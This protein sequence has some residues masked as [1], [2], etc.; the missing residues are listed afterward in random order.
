MDLNFIGSYA[1][2]RKDM[3]QNFLGS[4]GTY[5]ISR[6]DME[7]NFLGSYAISRKD[8]EQSF[9]NSYTI[10]RKMGSRENHQVQD[11]EIGVMF[12]RLKEVAEL[13]PMGWAM[14]S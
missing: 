14:A 5:S 13:R 3:E 6:K 4:L 2:S 9:S 1:I 11:V 12:V 10:S 8:T 7:L